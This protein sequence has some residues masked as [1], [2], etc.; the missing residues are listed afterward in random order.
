MLVVLMLMT[1]KFESAQ[2]W[3]KVWSTKNLSLE[4]NLEETG[5]E[6]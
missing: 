4:L 2:A 6:G 3:G 1:L 5:G